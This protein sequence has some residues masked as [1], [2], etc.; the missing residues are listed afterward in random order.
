MFSKTILD[1]TPNFKIETSQKLK[2][3]KKTATDPVFK[4]QEQLESQMKP[5]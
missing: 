1:Q 3:L 2:K 4:P 5:S